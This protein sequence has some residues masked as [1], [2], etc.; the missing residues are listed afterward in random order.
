MNFVRI[1]H[2]IIILSL[3][4]LDPAKLSAQGNDFLKQ[5]INESL[6][7]DLRNESLEFQPPSDSTSSSAGL[8]DINLQPTELIE[9]NVNKKP[10]PKLGYDFNF[11][12]LLIQSLD[13][14]AEEPRLWEIKERMLAAYT[15]QKYNPGRDK[16]TDYKYLIPQKTHDIIFNKGFVSINAIASAAKSKLNPQKKRIPFVKFSESEKT[17]IREKTNQIIW[18]IFYADYSDSTND[19]I[20]SGFS[21]ERDSLPPVR[22]FRQPP[23][24]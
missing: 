11:N 10:I 21:F 14:S 3:F 15:N 6:K 9:L 16:A 20:R 2:I 18:E 17:V 13:K 12:T 24:Y 1:K 23:Y 4:S 8:L 7:K 5:I 19:S 22:E